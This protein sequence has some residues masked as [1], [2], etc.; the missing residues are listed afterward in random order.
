LALFDLIDL[1]CIAIAA[2]AVVSVATNDHSA[3]R[4][5][6]VFIFALFIPGQAVVT[7]WPAIAARSPV[8][9]SVL[10]SLALLILFATAALWGHLWHPLGLFEVEAVVAIGAL[11]AGILRRWRAPDKTP[12]QSALQIEQNQ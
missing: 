3:V 4:A 9:V 10:F 8:A 11:I 12:T 1:A 2:I 7:N 6:A 5:V